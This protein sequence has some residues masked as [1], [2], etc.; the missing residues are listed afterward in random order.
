M[1]GVKS[2]R[3]AQRA[4]RSIRLAFL[5]LFLVASTVLGLLHLFSP[6]TKPVGVDALD[7]FGGIESAF[8]LIATGSMLSKIAWS[9]FILLFATL[10]TAI[11]FRRVFSDN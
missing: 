5:V 6:D 7:P 2:D 1:I 8:T 3:R 11:V 4:F 10:A 9:S